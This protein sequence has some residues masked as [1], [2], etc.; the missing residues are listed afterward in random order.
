MGDIFGRCRNKARRTRDDVNHKALN[1]ELPQ[2]FKEHDIWYHYE[3]TAKQKEKWLEFYS[4]IWRDYGRTIAIKVHGCD[5]NSSGGLGGFLGALVG[6]VLIG[7][8]VINP[9]FA[10]FSQFSL[11]MLYSS[12]VGLIVGQFITNNQQKNLLKAKMDTAMQA[13][14]AAQENARL[15][16]EKTSAQLTNNLIYSAYEICADGSIYKEGNAGS[17]TFTPS[18]SLQVEKGLIGE[19]TENYTD[20]QTQNRSQVYLAGGSRY[21]SETLEL[22]FPLAKIDKLDNTNYYQI[23]LHNKQKKMQ[24]GYIKL[25]KFIYSQKAADFLADMQRK[26][27]RFSIKFNQELQS[28]ENMIKRNEKYN[29]GLRQT[30]YITAPELVS[31]R[32][33]PLTTEEKR[34]E[35]EE[36]LNELIESLF[37]NKDEKY[38]TINNLVYLFKDIATNTLMDISVTKSLSTPLKLFGDNH[39]ITFENPTPKD[40]QITI[41]KPLESAYSLFSWFKE[42]QNYHKKFINKTPIKEVLNNEIIRYSYEIG[43]S[44]KQTI[45]NQIKAETKEMRLIQSLSFNPQG[46]ETIINL[47]ERLIKEINL[48]ALDADFSKA[49]LDAYDEG[50]KMQEIDYNA[51]SEEEKADFD[52]RQAEL[53]EIIAK[54]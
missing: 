19:D 39:K 26:D 47:R 30:D 22:P 35:R 21:M 15:E 10:A 28:S 44:E 46:D 25:Q 23:A 20:N 8:A 49:A 7:I 38:I 40:Y 36:E 24:E 41:N 33:I 14:Q 11:G 17:D 50:V 45:Q 12:G 13:M 27:L 6:V 54:G 18:T 48:I 37:L 51:L 2:I 3:D 31:E 53:L 5:P 16:N 52:K 42:V 29:Q 32:V 9:A 4:V 43:G 34:V 1:Y